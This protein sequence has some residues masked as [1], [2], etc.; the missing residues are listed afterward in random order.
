MR[1]HDVV[2]IGAGM[3]GASAAWALSEHADVLLVEQEA[4]AGHHATGRSAAVLSETSGTPLTCA[5][6]AASRPFLAAPPRDFVDHPLV[7]PRGLLWVGQPGDEA[8]L[9]ALADEGSRHARGV[10]RIGGDACTALF[11]PLRPGPASVGGVHEPD[12]CAVDVALLLQGYLRGLRR[13]GGAVRLAAGAVRGSR[14]TGTAWVVELASEAG[15]AEVSCRAVVNAAGAWGDAVARRFGVA[16][17]GLR[18]LRRTACIVPAPDGAADWPLV[19]D[20]AGRFYCEPETGGLLVSPADEAPSEPCDARPDELDVALGLE[21]LAEAT[22]LRPVHVRRAWAGL[23]T[24]SP[25]RSPVAGEDPD[26]IGFYWLVG[27]GG[28]GIKTAP[29]LA[30]LTAALVLGRELP[31]EVVARGLDAASLSPARF[32]QPSPTRSRA[33]CGE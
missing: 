23:R 8:A 25:D 31:Q 4:H 16:P 9:D 13:R 10:G 11:P 29:A 3:A 27:Q 20:V 2:V 28:A 6:A 22:T 24:F 19:M 1:H 7:S 26:H 5:L 21:R 12:A 33:A 32:R 30:A 15:E 17:L 14:R 18:P